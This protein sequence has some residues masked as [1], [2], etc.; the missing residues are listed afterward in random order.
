M[1]TVEMDLM[2]AQIGSLATDVSRLE[3]KVAAGGGIVVTLSDLTPV[4]ATHVKA[5]ASMAAA[6]LGQKIA[7][8]SNVVVKVDA[9]SFRP[10]EPIYYAPLVYMFISADT[11]LATDVGGNFIYVTDDQL[12]QEYRILIDMDGDADIYIKTTNRT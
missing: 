7:A 11:G 3:A 4:D 12:A 1:E 9:T 5:K 10:L 2:Q 6:E 8:G